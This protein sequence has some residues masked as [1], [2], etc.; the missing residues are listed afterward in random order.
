MVFVS[1]IIAVG[2]L[3][4]AILAYQKAA[5]SNN[6]ETQ[7]NSLREKSADAL[8]KLENALRKHQKEDVPDADEDKPE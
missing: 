4:I 7:L 2:A 6:L 5:G 1:F 3:I 8:A